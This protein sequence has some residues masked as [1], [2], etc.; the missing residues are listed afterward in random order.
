L[1]TKEKID[2]F[3]KILKHQHPECYDKFNVSVSSKSDYQQYRGMDGVMRAELN[4]NSPVKSEYIISFPNIDSLYYDMS[5]YIDFVWGGNVD[6]IATF[7][8]DGT[9]HFKFTV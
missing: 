3:L 2:Y 6:V 4:Y 7:D 5:F 8:F 9:N 1:E